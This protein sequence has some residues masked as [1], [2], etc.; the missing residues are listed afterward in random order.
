MSKT[1]LGLLVVVIAV[2]GYVGWRYF[3]LQSAAVRWEGKVEEILSEEIDKQGRTMTMKFT[4][5]IDAPVAEVFRA[6]SEP[7]RGPEFSSVIRS[8]KL[9]KSEGNTKVVELEAVILEQPQQMTL[10]FTFLPAE[11][12]VAIKTIES[13]MADLVGEYQ[14]TPSPDGTKTLLTYTATST[15]KMNL[16]VPVG[17]QKSAV[18][19]MFASSV[20][21]L[22][23]GVASQKQTSPSPPVP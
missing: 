17:V 12:R 9:L 6:F 4:S 23:K 19:E 3:Q 11:N 16:P 8:A 15:D 5:R 21:A 13:A 10:E 2:V 14:F 22:Q 1:R 18:R 20:R 7:E